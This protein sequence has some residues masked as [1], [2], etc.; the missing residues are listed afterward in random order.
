[1]KR[2]EFLALLGGAAAVY[3]LTARAA[4][5]TD[6]ADRMDRHRDASRLGVL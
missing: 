2:R 3:P 4:A 5:G 6:V 1:M